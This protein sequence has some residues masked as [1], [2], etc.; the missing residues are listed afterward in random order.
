MAA[1][2]CH[3]FRH[4]PRCQSVLKSTQFFVS[5]DG[6][7]LTLDVVGRNREE[8]PSRFVL[9][10]PAFLLVINSYLGQERRKVTYW[11]CSSRDKKTF[12]TQC[13]PR[14][15]SN[16]Y[17]DSTLAEKGTP[18]IA[19]HILILGEEFPGETVGF[20]FFLFF[21]EVDDNGCQRLASSSIRIGEL[22]KFLFHHGGFE[23]FENRLLMWHLRDWSIV[24]SENSFD[25]SIT[26]FVTL[27]F[28]V[29]RVGVWTVE[30]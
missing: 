16:R 9:E 2:H 3:R 17:D 20:F 29:S 10:I 22:K 1:R 26:N 25:T 6:D 7:S 4:P 11:Y 5:D 30:S 24:P 23:V 18:R 13:I 15:I 21:A 27:L 14:D 12:C 28:D 19:L 8:I